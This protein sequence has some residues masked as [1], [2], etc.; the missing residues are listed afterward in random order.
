MT[1]AKLRHH[2][3]TAAERAIPAD[4][5]LAIDPLA[6]IMARPARRPRGRFKL[7][8]ALGIGMASL[9]AAG[10]LAVVSG[11]VPI[12]F[13][14]RPVGQPAAQA[15]PSD[16]AAIEKQVGVGAAT[17]DQASSGRGKIGSPWVP[18]TLG[19]AQAAFG[20]D[21][22]VASH[23]APASVLFQAASSGEQSKPG[24]PA[25]SDVVALTYQAAG[26]TVT[27]SETRDSTD[28][29]LTID[30]ADANGPKLKADDGLGQ[31]VIETVA[32]N[33]YAVGYSVDGSSVV[34]VIFKSTSGVVAAVHFEPGVG[35]DA[36]LAFAT[37]LE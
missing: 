33:P 6:A 21:L 22:L 24:A 1:E 13:R 29:P 27:V 25:P 5:R 18:M 17:N 3:A 12:E 36:A 32:G 14:L 8:L 26:A 16:K 9:S 2:L 11:T 4:S 10:V 37:S 30:A 28:R 20:V 19:E 34:W 31:A 35:H 15:M 7:A 23:Q